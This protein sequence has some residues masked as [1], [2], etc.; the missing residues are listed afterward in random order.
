M[1]GVIK[2]HQIKH[3][4]F[5]E[6]NYHPEL[7]KGLETL[8]YH[9]EHNLPVEK[10]LVY[11]LVPE[12]FVHEI[13]KLD[14]EDRK[15]FQKPKLTYARADGDLLDVDVDYNLAN[16]K[17]NEYEQL[18]DKGMRMEMYLYEQTQ[19]LYSFYSDK[20]EDE[21]RYGGHV[22]LEEYL[23]VLEAM[24]DENR[25]DWEK[26]MMAEID[27]LRLIDDDVRALEAHLVQK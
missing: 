4:V 1:L 21:V 23:V 27:E 8:H 3:T 9:V 18:W 20:L 2:Y 25:K 10:E 7:L 14:W 17:L 11:Q 5:Q 19:D 22:G 26:R 24:D 15:R 16:N 6:L 13:N 12:L